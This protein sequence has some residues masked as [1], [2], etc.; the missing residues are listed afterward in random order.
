[1]FELLAPL[2]PRAVHFPIALLLAGT[3]SLF[4]GVWLHRDRWASYGRT[5]LV[6]GLLAMLIAM[7]TGL[8]DQARAPQSS[9]VTAVINQHITV[10]I[11]LLIAAGVAVYWPIRSKRL[12]S[13]SPARWGYLL[14]LLVIAV[15]VLAEGWL[16]GKLVYQLGVGVR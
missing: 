11:A 9:E 6:V 5:S 1:M 12:L 14:L 13:D 7:A 10:S 4:I 8:L 3:L 16:G 15:L 2:H